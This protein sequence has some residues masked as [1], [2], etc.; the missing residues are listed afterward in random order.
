[1]TRL[2]VKLRPGLSTRS[3]AARN[4]EPLYEPSSELQILPE[5]QW[6]IA[7]ADVEG[8]TAWDGAHRE[9]AS[10]LG[11]DEEDVLFAEPDLVHDIYRDTNERPG[12]EP[13]AV[14][15]NCA[16]VNQDGSNGKATGNGVAWH[17]DNGHSQ[18]AAARGAVAFAA[19]RTRMAHI[20]TGYFRAHETTP[21]HI[22]R[23]LERSFVEADADQ[24]SAEDPDRK[25]LLLD[26]SGHGTGTLGI[27]AGGPSSL[28]GPLAIG[29]APEAEVVP[30][31]VADSV[32]LLRTSALARALDY[33][34]DKQCDVVTMSMGGL[35]SRAWAEAVD[36]L[37]E[38][39]LC[40]CA[41]AGNHVGVLPP[42][43]LVYPAR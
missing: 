28:H 21:A 43:T 25:V 34:A 27:L 40:I 18:L 22:L 12:G 31:R 7:H 19:P 10:A 2:L 14:G 5:P 42:R 36:E 35:P 41:A 4:L 6:F 11:L 30:L 13:F 29:G 20:D 1:M 37:Y 24:G 9:V 32:V 3:L 39:G 17:L 8:E 15:D 38:A 33:A 23:S 16:A 26:N